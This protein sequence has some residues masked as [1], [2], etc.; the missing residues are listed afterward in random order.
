LSGKLVVAPGP[1]G[2]EPN[3]RGIRPPGRGRRGPTSGSNGSRLGKLPGPVPD[4]VPVP[5]VPPRR[6]DSWPVPV[7][8]RVSPPIIPVPVPAPLPDDKGG[9][10]VG[11]CARE[12]ATRIKARL[13]L[14][15]AA[16]FGRSR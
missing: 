2:I 8:F 10:L 16:I 4:S 9:P 14:R 7:V 6:P 1:S 13:T 12:A 3:V 11:A 5:V 15:P